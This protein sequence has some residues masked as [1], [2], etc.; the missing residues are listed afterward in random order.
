MIRRSVVALVALALVLAPGVAAA[1]PPSSAPPWLDARGAAELGAGRPLVVLVVV[2]LC[3]ERLIACGSRAFGDPVRLATNLYWG[4]LYGARRFFERSTSAYRPVSRFTAPVAPATEPR[5][6]ELGAWL[7]SGAPA[8]GEDAVLER[9]IY[10]REVDAA[11]FG[12]AGG[13]RVE[14]I[15]VL[16]AV[17]GDAIDA[18]LARFYALA[19]GGGTVAFEDAGRV[20]RE[21]VHVAGYAGHNRLMDGVALPASAG[22]TPGAALPSFVLACASE[23]YFAAPLAS[24]GSRAL[25]LTRTL[26]APEGYVIEATVDALGRGAAEPEIRAAAVAAYARWQSLAPAVAESVFARPAPPAR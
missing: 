9:A 20:R 24:A 11:P 3:D 4:A 5:P 21:R 14:Q 10:R 13:G 23:P 25:L 8:P 6:A 19:E 18:A 1:A 26:M 17:R 16:E 12:L 15:V 2:P 22:R 7:A